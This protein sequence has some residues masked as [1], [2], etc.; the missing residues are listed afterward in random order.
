MPIQAHDLARMDSDVAAKHGA[1]RLL[2]MPVKIAS[3][4]GSRRTKVG[5]MSGLCSPR[6]PTWRCPADDALQQSSLRAHRWGQHGLQAP[7]K[8]L[9][10]VR[11][12]GMAA[13]GHQFFCHHQPLFSQTDL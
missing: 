12:Q 8:W 3:S 9:P 7:V 6:L 2:P 11:L 5:M 13:E 4:E 1:R 10:L